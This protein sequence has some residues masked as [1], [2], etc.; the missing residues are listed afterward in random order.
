MEVDVGS[1]TYEAFA[2][3]DTASEYLAGDV[4]R[5]DG[6]ALLTAD[7]Q[8]RALVSAT[9]MM[10]VLPWCA[11]APDPAADPDPVVQEVAVMLAADL[12]ADP[13]LFA[14]ASGNSNVK[15]VSAASGT[16]VE[17]FSPVSGG[18]P[19]PRALWDRLR[20]AGLVCLD[21]GIDLMTGPMSLGT[22]E[23]RPIGGRWPW[24]WPIAA[25]DYD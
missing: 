20:K 1:N 2:D 10:L 8:G 3:Q 9:R 23:C 19:I 5:A 7:Q 14:D 12:A 16:S 15:V 24:D 18:P 11:D 22:A 21:S 17:F 25:L 6:W 4:A 13:K